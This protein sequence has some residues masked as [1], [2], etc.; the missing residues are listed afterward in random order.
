VKRFALLL[1]VAAAGGLAYWKWP[2]AGEAQEPPIERAGPGYLPAGAPTGPP[3]APAPPEG[4][5]GIEFAT[6]SAF[7]YDP[8][9]DNVPDEIRALDGTRVQL[10]GV[11]YYG[12]D[13]PM[14]VVEFHLM[15]NHGICCFG[16]PRTNE[17]VRV[18]L[19]P[20][21]ATRY[22]LDYYVVRGTID[23]RAVRDAKGRVLHLYRIR[24]AEADVLQ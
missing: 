2:K 21:L 13:D 6:L 14:R 4:F 11:M 20:G 18:E 9:V 15:P 24:D 1:V 16:T 22:V 23:V 7:D 5:A 3:P 19:R 10:V 17:V 8:E 12:V